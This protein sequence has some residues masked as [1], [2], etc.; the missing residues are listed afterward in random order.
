VVEPLD[1][2]RPRHPLLGPERVD[3]D[4]HRRA[5]DVLE[6]ERV[7]PRVRALDHPVRDLRDLELAPHRRVDT[8]E[9]PPVF[10]EPHELPQIEEAHRV[11]WI[12]SGAPGARCTAEPRV[13]PGAAALGPAGGAGPGCP[14]AEAGGSP[15][16]GGGRRGAWGW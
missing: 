2:E 7:V 12:L 9:L 3:E 4:R 15:T 14:C 11:T 6:E 1:T 5:L 8:A 10:Q 16:P 13:A